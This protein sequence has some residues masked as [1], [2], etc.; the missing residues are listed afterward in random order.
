MRKIVLM[1]FVFMGFFNS[2]AQNT[3]TTLVL[4]KLEIKD[5]NDDLIEIL[6]RITLNEQK[7][8]GKLDTLLYYFLIARTHENLKKALDNYESVYITGINDEWPMPCKA[9]S[10]ILGY[11]EVGNLFFI[12]SDGGGFPKDYFSNLFLVKDIKKSFT[13][14]EYKEK[15]IFEEDDS[16]IR[17]WCHFLHKD[18]LFKVFETSCYDNNGLLYLFEN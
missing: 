1:S 11:I 7:N 3:G 2:F 12:V 8:Y 10:S 16:V 6:N 14:S 5:G 18:G 15:E 17:I 4:S 13:L 9:F